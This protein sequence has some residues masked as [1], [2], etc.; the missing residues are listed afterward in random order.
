MCS[1]LTRLSLAPVGSSGLFRGAAT[2]AGMR[3]PGLT[4]RSTSLRPF[5]I[6]HLDNAIPRWEAISGFER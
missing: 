6:T 4:H 5:A 2:R 1:R 3:G